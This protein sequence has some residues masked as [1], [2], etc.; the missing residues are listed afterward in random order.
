MT[1]VVGAT[2]GRP[3]KISVNYNGRQVV[4]PIK[5]LFDSGKNKISDV[6]G[7]TIGRPIKISANYNGRQAV[8]PAKILTKQKAERKLSAF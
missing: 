2:I 4:A 3:I 7:A 6:V 1:I 5:I 8:V